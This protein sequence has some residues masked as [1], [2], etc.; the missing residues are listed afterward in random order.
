MLRYLSADIICSDKRKVFRERTSR[1]AVCSVA[2]RNM[3][4]VFYFTTLSLAHSNLIE[5]WERWSSA[6]VVGTFRLRRLTTNFKRLAL[7]GRAVAIFYSERLINIRDKEGFLLFKSTT[8]WK[9]YHCFSK[10]WFLK[11]LWCVN[12]DNA[13]A[14]S[15]IKV[16]KQ[17]VHYLPFRFLY[18]QILLSSQCLQVSKHNCLM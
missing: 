10:I 9:C 13:L 15:S 7:G 18:R 12:N 2:K 16:R 1:K 8:R 6:K 4:T 3:Q 5:V 11:P 14:A 17:N